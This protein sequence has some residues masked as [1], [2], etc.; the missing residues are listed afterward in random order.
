MEGSGFPSG[1]AGGLVFVLSLSLALWSML[2]LV[3]RVG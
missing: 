1:L 3:R 2:I